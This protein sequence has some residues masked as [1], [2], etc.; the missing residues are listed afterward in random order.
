MH[1]HTCPAQ[2]NVGGSCACRGYRGSS[3]KS[4][5]DDI[6]NA[7]R[8]AKRVRSCKIYTHA[9]GWFA[10]GDLNLPIAGSGFG[11]DGDWARLAL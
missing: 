5:R 9:C 8:I 6:N 3:L 4:I 10:S 2:R 7:L 1:L 11:L